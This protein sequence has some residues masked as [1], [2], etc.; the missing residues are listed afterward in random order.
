MLGDEATAAKVL[1]VDDFTIFGAGVTAGDAFKGA[2]GALFFATKVLGEMETAGEDVAP[3][4]LSKTIETQDF[5]DE[6][7]T[8]GFVDESTSF[9]SPLLSKTIVFG[10]NFKN[11]QKVS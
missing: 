4:T 5:R 1:T 8:V 2:D 7:Q 3:V 11:F 10:N 9:A 6:N